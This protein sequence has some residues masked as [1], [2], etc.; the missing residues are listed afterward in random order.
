MG[1]PGEHHTDG[2]GVETAPGRA[3]QG[4]PALVNAGRQHQLSTLLVQEGAS[5]PERQVWVGPRP[6]H[7][8]TDR[9]QVRSMGAATPRQAPAADALLRC[10]VACH[11][12]ALLV[13]AALDGPAG[14]IGAVLRW[15]S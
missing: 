2:A 12:D 8:G 7:V 1:R 15:P 9:N 13:P 14:G 10:A 11:A 5:D 6:E 3:A 4:I